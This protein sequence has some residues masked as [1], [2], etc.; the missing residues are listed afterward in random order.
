[1]EEGK[2]PKCGHYNLDY[3]ALEVYGQSIYYPW[4]CPDCGASGK[5]WYSL[6]VEEQELVEEGDE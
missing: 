4:T 1:M 5:E 6:V 3:E 2:C